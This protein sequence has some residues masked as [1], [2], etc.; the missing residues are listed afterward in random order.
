MSFPPYSTHGAYKVEYLWI[1]GQGSVRGKT[2]VFRNPITSVDDLPEWNYDGSST[3]QADGHDSEVLIVPKALFNDPF[4]NKE[5]EDNH[6]LALCD[7]YLPDGSPHPTNTRVKAV[8]KFL[9]QPELQPM[10]GIEQEFF[11]VERGWP[12][13]FPSRDSFPAP[14][15]DYYC[16]TG[17]PHAVG[18]ECIEKSFNRCLQA[19]LKLTGLNAEVAPSQWEFQVCDYGI[20]VCDQLY[21]LRYILRRTAEEY[22]W[23][24]DFEPK[25]VKGDWNGSGCHTNFST[26]PMREDGG[27]QV[28]LE[29]I[30]RL[31]EK[32]SETMAL[33]GEGNQERMTGQHET[34]DYNVFSFG[35]A[36]RG[37]SIRIPRSTEANGKGYFED[38]RPSSN[39]DP[40]L[41]TSWLYQTSCGH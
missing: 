38:R 29:S 23:D 33:Y 12:V 36:D 26:K 27:Y 39:M 13:G 10:F 6:K 30:N 40:Y 5:G 1:D 28:I 24:V 14:Q 19:G 25:P 11:L 7:T 8:E 17:F 2:R 34:A 21:V 35:V 16:G 31:S 37:S 22:G 3:G 9:V 32:H 20:D 4:R 41:V 15:G 18:R